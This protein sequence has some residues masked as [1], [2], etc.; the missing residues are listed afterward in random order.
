M[1]GWQELLQAFVVGTIFFFLW[2]AST[3]A[4]YRTGVHDGWR[5]HARPRDPLWNMQRE[6][7]ARYGERLDPL[8]G[9]EVVDELVET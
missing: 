2:L 1:S 7:V 8:S 4:A 5:A 9:A 3:R 6:I